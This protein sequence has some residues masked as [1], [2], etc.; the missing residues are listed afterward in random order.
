MR[1]FG[2]V[3][4]AVDRFERAAWLTLPFDL[5]LTAASSNVYEETWGGSVSVDLDDGT[6]AEDRDLVFAGYVGG[7]VDEWVYGGTRTV[8]RGGRVTETQQVVFG[9]DV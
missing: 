4:S 6:V 2:K 7:N 3:D 9:R 8:N 1:L 5:A